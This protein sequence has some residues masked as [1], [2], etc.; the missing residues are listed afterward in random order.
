MERVPVH[1]TVAL[2]S[3][4]KLSGSI[5]FLP[6]EGRAGPAAS[7]S[8]VEGSYKFDRSNGPTAGPHTVTV[9]RPLTR[10][11]LYRSR[12]DTKTVAKKKMEWTRSADVLDD[13]QYLQDFTL[14]D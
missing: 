2:A 8:L 3:G 12:A 14:D 4:E 5:T 7:A 1:G 11:N 9:R 13:G 10:T 6:A